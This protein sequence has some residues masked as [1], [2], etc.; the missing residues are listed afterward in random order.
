LRILDVGCGAGSLSAAL[1]ARGAAYIAGIELDP[2]AAAAARE[3]LDEVVEG[4]ATEQELPWPAESFDVL[5][6]ADVLEHLPDP[7]VVLDRFVP[8]LAQDGM[9]IVSVPNWRFWS[10]L[11]RLACDRWAYTDRG[12][13]DRTHLRVFTRRTLLGM[14]DRHGLRVERLQRNQRLFDDQSSINRLGAV[15]TRMAGATL[16]RMFPDLMT[17]QYVAVARKA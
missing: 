11:L 14:L 15:A 6:L 13:R 4:S 12:V 7:D 5:V 8:L 16:G 3:R 1:K 10:V 17:Y 9:V 2:R